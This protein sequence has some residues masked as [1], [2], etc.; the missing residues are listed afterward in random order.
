MNSLREIVTGL[1]LKL[2]L[3]RFYLIPPSFSL[4]TAHKCPQPGCGKEFSRHD[5]LAQHM[6][7]HRN[8]SAPRDGGVGLT[9]QSR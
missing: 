1:K 9:S 5:N 7:V 2:K 4:Y 3:T 6:R 8:Y